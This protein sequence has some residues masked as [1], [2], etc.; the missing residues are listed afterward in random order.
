MSRLF[1][2]VPKVILDANVLFPFTLRDTLL[3]VAARG[4]IRVYWSET[5]LEE[6]TRNLVSTGRMNEQQVAHLMAAMRRAFP[7]AMVVDYEPLIPMMENDKKDRHVAAVAVKAQAEM[8]VTSNTR[9]FVPLPDGIVARNPDL[10]LLGLIETAPTELVEVLREQARALRRPPVSFEE[11]L[12]GL[13]K[14]VP[15]FVEAV[16]GLG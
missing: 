3:R 16:R 9:D 4:Y 5:I 6:A 15:R 13:E 14:S 10:F 11:L 12:L 1:H 2:R 8:V 7:D